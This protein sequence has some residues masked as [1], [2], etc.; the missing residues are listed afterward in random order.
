MWNAKVMKTEMSPVFSLTMRG[1]R[2][3]GVSFRAIVFRQLIATL[4]LSTMATVIFR[5]Y[6]LR[7]RLTKCRLPAVIQVLALSSMPISIDT[8][9]R[10]RLHCQETFPVPDGNVFVY[11]DADHLNSIHRMVTCVCVVNGSFRFLMPWDV[12]F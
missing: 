8:L 4:I 12:L 11:D 10:N 9:R 5:R 2:Y 1:R 3:C 7:Q 6:F